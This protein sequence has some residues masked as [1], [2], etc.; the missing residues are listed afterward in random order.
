MLAYYMNQSEQNQLIHKLT[1]VGRVWYMLLAAPFIVYPLI[2]LLASCFAN[3]GPVTFVGLI[4]MF[5]FR[6]SHEHRINHISG[7]LVHC[8]VV[9]MGCIGNLVFQSVCRVWYMLWWYIWSHNSKTGRHRKNQKL[10]STFPMLIFQ[11]RF[12]KK[13]S[14]WSVVH[15]HGQTHLRN[16][17]RFKLDI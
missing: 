17:C 6:L 10:V 11:F 14:C 12:A 7:S 15:G 13:H 8:A 1:G 9:L 16:F 4:V 3:Q 5:V 2:L